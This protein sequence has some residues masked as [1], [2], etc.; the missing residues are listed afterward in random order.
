MKIP[1]LARACSSSFA[2]N[3]FEHHVAVN[4]SHYGRA[5]ADALGNYKGWEVYHHK[6]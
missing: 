1:G 2:S 5:V 3:G 6:A 4:R